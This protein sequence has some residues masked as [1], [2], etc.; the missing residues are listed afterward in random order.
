MYVVMNMNRIATALTLVNLIVLA[1]LLTRLQPAIA[2]ATQPASKPSV[3]R[4]TGL[5]IVDRSG[6]IRASIT[7]EP[8]VVVNGIHYPETVLLRLTDPKFGPLVKITADANGSA[9]GL[10]DEAEGGIQILARDTGMVFR[11]TH[12]GKERVIRP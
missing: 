9:I 2:Q 7:V 10:S 3:L 12:R 8:P 1:I 6:R 5:E 4:G 11:M